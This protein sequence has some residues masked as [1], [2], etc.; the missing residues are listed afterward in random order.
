VLFF[1]FSPRPR[2]DQLRLLDFA[3]D[4]EF[5]PILR[6]DQGVGRAV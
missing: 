5:S 6:R 1:L 2:R 4:A 3:E